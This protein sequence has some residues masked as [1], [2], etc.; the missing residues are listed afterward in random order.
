MV[1]FA[2][3]FLTLGLTGILVLISHFVFGGVTAGVAGA[4]TA[5]FVGT[6]WFGVPLSRRRKAQ[7]FSSDRAG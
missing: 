1:I 4:L 6:L 5:I 3:A 2:A 7:Q